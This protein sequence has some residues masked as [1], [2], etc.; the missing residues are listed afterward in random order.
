MALKCSLCTVECFLDHTFF[1]LLQNFQKSFIAV[2]MFHGAIF[3]IVVYLLLE[4]PQKVSIK[5]EEIQI[6]APKP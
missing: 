3:L 6:L 5:E 4:E 1:V 2:S